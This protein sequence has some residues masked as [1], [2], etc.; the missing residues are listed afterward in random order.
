[1]HLFFNLLNLRSFGFASFI[2]LLASGISTSLLFVVV[3][4]ELASV[5][6][7]VM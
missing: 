4:G 1:M 5:F 7:V 3:A 2:H 6:Y